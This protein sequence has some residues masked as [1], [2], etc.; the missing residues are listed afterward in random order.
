MTRSPDQRSGIER[1]RP[2]HA[3][4]SSGMIREPGIDDDGNPS[5][6]EELDH[7]HGIGNDYQ[8]RVRWGFLPQ[9]RDDVNPDG[10]VSRRGL[11]ESNHD[12]RNRGQLSPRSMWSFRKC[13][14]H[15]MQGS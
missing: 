5:P 1:V 15:E 12:S 9:L 14:E 11:A 7:L 13:V 3:E 4:R 2:Q 8:V 10:I 6:A